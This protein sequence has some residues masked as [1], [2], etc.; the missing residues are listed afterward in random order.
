MRVKRKTEDLVLCLEAF[1]LRCNCCGVLFIYVFWQLVTSLK[2]SVFDLE[3][4]ISL[5]KFYSY[6]WRLCHKNSDSVIYMLAWLNLFS[7]E[8]ETQ[9]IPV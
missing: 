4:I 7:H 3:P 9:W 1:S 2:I 8:I 6:Y 5:S